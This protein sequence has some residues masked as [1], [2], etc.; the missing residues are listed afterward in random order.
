MKYL[1]LI[2]GCV[3]LGGCAFAQDTLRLLEPVIDQAAQFGANSAG[4]A[5]DEALKKHLGEAAA[6]DWTGGEIAATTG[7]IVMSA[8]G[9]LK[10]LLYAWNRQK[11]KA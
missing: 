8:Y 9:A 3:L 11:P 7:G 2:L 5:V 1:L 4:M 10:G 6:N